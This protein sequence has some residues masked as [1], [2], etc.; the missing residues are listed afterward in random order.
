MVLGVALGVA[1]LSEAL[2]VPEVALEVVGF[3]EV[4][5]VDSLLVRV[6]RVKIITTWSVLKKMAWV[7]QKDADGA[8]LPGFL[9]GGMEKVHHGVEV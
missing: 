9:D 5:K 8:G 6:G 2:V 1:F 3:G 4:L 7:E